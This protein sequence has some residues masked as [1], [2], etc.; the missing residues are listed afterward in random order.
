[1]AVRSFV[2]GAVAATA[3]S[4]AALAQ[5]V[6]TRLPDIPPSQYTDAQK[7]A[8]DD[9]Q[10]ARKAPLTGP[11]LPLMHSPELMTRARAMGDYLRYR[12][13]I[14]NTLS[15]LAILITSREWSQDYEW[16]AHARIAEKAG[17]SSDIIEAIRDGR[18]PDHMSPDEAAVYDFAVELLRNKRVSDPT[19]QRIE[20][21]FGKKGAVDLTGILGYYT[22]LAM[23]LNVARY[24]PPQPMPRMPRFPD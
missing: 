7:Q 4:A 3:C 23:Q 11:F 18:R 1:M 13:A 17:I 14:G 22:L 5:A 6:N 16:L 9:F 15:E 20:S 21:R 10:A 24:Q 19:F 2:L 12:S 8:A